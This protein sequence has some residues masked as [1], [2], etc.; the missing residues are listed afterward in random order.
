MSAGEGANHDTGDE[1]RVRAS[2][3]DIY[4]RVKRE[5]AGELDR[6]V[7]AL[8]FSGLFAGASVGFGAVASAAAA[9]ALAGHSDARL[10]GALF[11]PIGFIVVHYQQASTH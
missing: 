3:A 5:A 4:E 9:V 10:V 11:F 2:A 8:A 6:P 1:G 7:A